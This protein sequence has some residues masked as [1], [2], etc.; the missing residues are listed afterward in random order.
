MFN[1]PMSFPVLAAT[2]AAATAVGTLVEGGLS[3]VFDFSNRNFKATV[4]AN[5]AMLA[6]S[7]VLN[8]LFQMDTLPGVAIN[9]VGSF[10]VGQQV[11]RHIDPEYNHLSLKI[12]GTVA[13]LPIA[14]TAWALYDSYQ[15]FF[16]VRELSKLSDLIKVEMEKA[17]AEIL[18][19]GSSCVYQNITNSSAFLV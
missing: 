13:A 11:G 6:T 16:Y 19:K 5:T 4:Y 18:A 17:Q 15:N 2:G 8:Q 10:Y 9:W 12:K 3:R 1:A 14:F 7:L